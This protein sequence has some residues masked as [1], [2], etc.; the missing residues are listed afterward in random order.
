MPI[1]CFE[2]H[3]SEPLIIVIAPRDDR[4]EVPHLATIGIRYELAEGV[5]DH[6]YSVVADQEIEFWC[7]AEGVDVDI[8][9]PGPFDRLLWDICVG[10]GFCGSVIDGKPSHVCDLIPASGT[11]TAGQFADLVIQ[12]EGCARDSWRESLS[13][14]FVEHFGAS[15]VQAERLQTNVRRPFDPA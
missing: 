8:V 7:N 13:A 6:C 1:L 12:A 4:H 9:Y 11:V 2:N 3:Q 10:H 14:K 5:E 15:V